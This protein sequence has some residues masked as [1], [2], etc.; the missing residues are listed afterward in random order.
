MVPQG[1]SGAVKVLLNGK[2]YG[3]F[4]AGSFASIAVFGYGGDD[5]IEL[6]GSIDVR[7]CLNGGA[8]NDRLKGGAGNDILLGGAGDDLLV[9]GSGRDLLIGG[10]GA[11]RLVGNSDDDILIAGWTDHDANDAALCSI[12]DEWTSTR[13]YAKRTAN[14][15]NTHLKADGPGAT[16][17]DDGAHDV[18]TGSAGQDLFFAQLDGDAGT[19]KDKITDLSASEFANDIDFVTGP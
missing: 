10:F 8:G 9:G 11:D 6:A 7:S 19:V 1:S 5:D 13:S 14:L 16:V 4:A 3:T 17:H 2:D 18:L 12:M 15:V